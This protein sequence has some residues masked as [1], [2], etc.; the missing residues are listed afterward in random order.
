MKGNAAELKS[1]K[2]VRGSE[3]VSSVPLVYFDVHT[4][5]EEQNHVYLFSF[6]CGS[7][8]SLLKLCFNTLSPSMELISNVFDV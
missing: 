8:F 3:G 5:V 6:C 2:V 1:V 4:D 7:L